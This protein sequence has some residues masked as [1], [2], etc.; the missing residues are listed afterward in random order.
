VEHARAGEVDA[1]TLRDRV[2]VAFKAT[3]RDSLTSAPLGAGSPPDG[4]DLDPI[5]SGPIG[6]ALPGRFDTMPFS[7]VRQAA[8]NTNP[9]R[10]TLGEGR[11]SI[12]VGGD[13]MSLDIPTLF[14]IAVFVSAVAGFL[15][16]LSWLQNRSIGAL[17]W[18]ASSLIIGS[19]GV[20]LI[21]A[22]GDISDTWSITVANAILA[23]AYGMIWAGVRNFDGRATS[24]PLV[25]AGAVIWLVACRFE[26]FFTS[27]QARTALMSA[28]VVSYS[29]L[30]A[31]ELW[32]GR[33]EGLIFRLPVILLL[34]VHA[35]FFVVR[36]PLADALPLATDSA[37]I[38]TGRWTFTIFEAVFFAFCIP[39]LLGAMARE[40]MVLGY[41]RASLI[42]PLTGVANRRAFFERGEKLLHRSAFDCLPTVLLS[43]DLDGFKHINDTFG[44]PVGDQVLI[45]F[46]GTATAALRPDDLFGRL[47]GEEFA[48]LLPRT[49]LDE[50]LAVAERIRSNFEA[51]T[52]EIGTN[53]LAATVSVGAAMSID[54]SRNLADI[55]TAADR[56]LYRAKANGRNRVECASGMPEDQ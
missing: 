23:S 14:V 30:S 45:A 1:G 33:R 37:E 10:W 35:A 55:I 19:I 22:R 2:L 11:R 20:A 46:C 39:Y 51:V 5:P 50:G 12:A 28:V 18:W 38:L 48:S 15:L 53:T 16:L 13:Y 29:L 7:P 25:F 36:I 6:M 31:W 3:S 26:A 17:A 54:P 52:L 27:P 49:S 21:A 34:L 40:R 41:K 43:F 4:L 42:D 9:H 56:A 24:A 32:R 44:H 47:G 8:A